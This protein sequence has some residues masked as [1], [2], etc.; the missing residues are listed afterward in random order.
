ML[1]GGTRTQNLT[2]TYGNPIL[3]PNYNCNYMPILYVNYKCITMPLATR[4]NKTEQPSQNL[5]QTRV[6]LKTTPCHVL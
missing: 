1:R 3:N 6:Y 4:E 2:H 5:I